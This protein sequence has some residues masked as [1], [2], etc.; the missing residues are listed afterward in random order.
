MT[1]QSTPAAGVEASITPNAFIEA[2]ENPGL[3]PGL[4]ATLALDVGTPFPDL[5]PGQINNFI[6]SREAAEGVS[7]LAAGPAGIPLAM[8]EFSRAFGD[9]GLSRFQQ[10]LALS[11]G[12]I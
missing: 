5:S 12:V 6:A 7:S 2:T 4:A 1:I 11:Y 8:N 10:A 9:S 3:L